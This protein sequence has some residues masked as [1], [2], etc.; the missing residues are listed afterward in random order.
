MKFLSLFA[1]LLLVISSAASA[2]DPTNDPVGENDQTNCESYEPGCERSHQE[3]WEEPSRPN[4]PE[5]PDDPY[6]PGDL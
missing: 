6:M 2:N 1:L 5:N 4:Y 3:E